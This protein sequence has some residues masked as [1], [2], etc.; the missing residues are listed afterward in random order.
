[1]RRVLFAGPVLA[2]VLAGCQI[3]TL[4][5]QPPPGYFRAFDDIRLPYVELDN[6]ADPTWADGDDFYTADLKIYPS[7]S[8]R[9]QV[10]QAFRVG[11]KVRGQSS[12]WM[13]KKSFALEVRDPGQTG[14]SLDANLAGFPLA[15]D[16]VLHA[17]YSDKT[18]LRNFTAYTLSNRVGVY[19]PRVRAIELGSRLLDGDTLPAYQGVYILVEKIKLG[20]YRVNAD[21]LL[22]VD[23]VGGQEWY[24]PGVSTLNFSSAD[25]DS[26]Q[27]T[28]DQQNYLISFMQGLEAAAV[29][30]LATDREKGWRKYLEEQ[31]FVDYFLLQELYRNVDGYRISTYFNLTR[32]GKLRAGP[33][34]D[35]DIALGNADYMEGY[36]PDN[37]TWDDPGTPQDERAL[38]WMLVYQL[39]PYWADNEPFKPAFWMK[40]L[41]QDPDFRAL[42]R[43]RWQ[44]W[45]SGLLSDAGI[46]QVLQAARSRLEPGLDRN[47][48][49]WTTLNQQDWPNPWPIPWNA[50]DPNSGPVYT[51]ND[52]FEYLQQWLLRRAHWMDSDLAWT[53]L[54]HA[55]A[56]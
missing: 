6:Y 20:K 2:L 4:S 9:S 5:D 28:P 36:N 46:G 44:E 17:S 22:K 42:C 54:A 14:Q 18:L 27:I 47:Y 31:T 13:P 43:Q 25:P 30:P 51:Y 45:R 37:W 8:D 1:M 40:A 41:L 52:H 35:F 29:S 7:Y 15:N 55:F 49:R 16:F 34:W 56:P 11:Q 19:A 21:F 48:S 50:K 10:L 3:Q 23:K 38:G 53:S 26:T 24:P 33:I 39:P 12:S 32:G